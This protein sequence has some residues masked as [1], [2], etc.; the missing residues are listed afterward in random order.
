MKGG[1]RSYVYPGML[2]LL[3]LLAACAQIVNPAGGPKDRI[4]PQPVKYI[5]DSAALNFKAKDIAIIFNEYIQL[6]DANTQLVISPPLKYAPDLKV[7]GRTLNIHFNDTLRDNT[8]YTLSFGSSIRDITEGNTLDNFQYVFSTGPYIDSLTLAG[9]VLRAVDGKPDKNVLVMLYSTEDD[10]VPYKA[11]PSYFSKTGNDGRYRIHNIRP[12]K[13][14]AFAL[15]DANNDY[16][17]NLPEEAIGFHGSPVTIAKKKDTLD[18]ALFQ[19]VQERIK[20]KKKYAPQYG[21]IVLVFTGPAQD[22]QLQSIGTELKNPLMEFSSKRDTVTYWFAGVE[23]E[24]LAVKVISNGQLVDTAEVKLIS[25]ENALKPRRGDKLALVPRTNVSSALPFDLKQDIDIELTNP[26]IKYD[27]AKIILTK[28]KD[29]LKFK[30]AFI[31]SVHRKLSISYPFAADSSYRLSLKSG[32]FEDIFGLASDTLN[33]S[34]RVQPEKFYGNL[35]MTVTQPAGSYV[36]QLVNEK[37][38]VVRETLVK[39]NVTLDYQYLKPGSYR[40]KRVYDTNS[41]GKWDTGNYLKKIQPEKVAFYPE[42]IVIRSNWD[43]ELDWKK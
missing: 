40:L 43:L 26:V 19:E 21:R 38:A 6:Q 2:A 24:N 29:T 16:L 14:Q 5:P 11:L 1:K 3:L 37:D 28:G 42:A 27:L 32:A 20:V 8:T 36:M 34:F 31:D 30:T 18:I 17:Y 35:K 12:G 15:R 23:Q 4:A 25:K 33:V 41:N 22:L 13:Y 9:R 10:S 39:G 7:K